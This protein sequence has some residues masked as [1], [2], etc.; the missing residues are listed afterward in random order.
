MDDERHDDRS[1]PGGDRDFITALAR[2]LDVIQAFTNQNREMTISQISY[3]TGITR[4][5]VRRYLHT[6][7][8]LGYARTSDGKGFSLCAK[9]ASLGHAY[10]SGTPLA[11]GVQAALDRLSER[12]GEGCSMAVLDDTDIVY[13]ARA[14]SSRILS[15]SLNVGNRL[16]AYATS[17][18]QVLLAHLPADALERYF[19]AAR[20]VPYTTFTLVT[21][22]ELLDEFARIRA[23]GHAIADQQME[24]GLR[25]IAAPIPSRDDRVVY[26]VNVI[27]PSA[28]VTIAQMRKD[29]LPPLRE[30]AAKIGQ[31]LRGGE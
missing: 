28:R 21:R 1:P 12:V 6:L 16:P 4:A 26:G 30:A 19:A 18:G 23:Q 31:L 2:G 17:I 25:S 7:C 13:V 5:A 3:K 14:T 8:V 11:G 22:E 27:A 10:L 24:I 29:F 15:P 9:T 20:L